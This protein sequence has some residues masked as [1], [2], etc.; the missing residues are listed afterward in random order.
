LN[1]PL[2]VTLSLAACVGVLLSLGFVFVQEQS[3]RSMRSATQVDAHLGIP[4]MAV[5]PA[6]PRR[7]RYSSLRNPERHLLLAPPSAP[8]ID[9]GPMGRMDDASRSRA[10]LT[11]AFAA[12]RTSVMLNNG[13][14][15]PRSLL[16]TS[17]SPGEGKTTVAVNLA[18]S[19]A[20][21]SQRV[22]LIDF[23]LRRPSVAGALNLE[24]G[25][26]LS[27]CLMGDADWRVC[28]QTVESLDVLT[29]GSATAGGPAEMALS[30]R[31]RQLL[32]E[33]EDEY[34]FVIL[35]SAPVL[36]YPAD[37]RS[38]A[39]LVDGTLLT[40]RSGFTSREAV[41]EAWTKLQRPLGVVLNA[42]SPRDT[43]AYMYPDC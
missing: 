41:R 15:P 28:R 30:P 7:S 37:V 21:L 8:V 31:L 29:A 24:S 17:A 5:I 33:A 6:V 34:D 23:D 14:A 36:T 38:L 11:E 4:A 25:P 42:A 32:T 18:L 16:I 35:D 9:G 12:L 19:L 39:A 22:L 13:E 43:S 40:V 2:S 27:D 20:R 10:A 26:G 1:F 3:D